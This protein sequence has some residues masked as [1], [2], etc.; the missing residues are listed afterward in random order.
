MNPHFPIPTLERI[1]TRIT[2]CP[3]VEAIFE[4]RFASSQPWE[5]M[6]GLLYAQIRERYASQKKL[7]L[8]DFPDEIRRQQPGLRDLPLL[9]FHSNRFLI[10]IGPRCVSLVTQPNAYPGWALIR[11]ELVWML[12]RLQAAGFVQETERLGVRYID[13]FDTNV[14]ENLLV[15][16]HLGHGPVTAAQTRR[17]HDHPTSGS[18]R[19]ILPT[20]NGSQDIVYPVQHPTGIAG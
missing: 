6:P 19:F 11:E 1:P 8:A 5:N 20:R 15:H 7:P 12:D 14:F 3:I 10:Q 4:V 17:I 13:F 18:A 9:Q 2:P 16:L